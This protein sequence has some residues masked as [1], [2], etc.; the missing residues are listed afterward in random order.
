MKTEYIQT[1]LIVYLVL[2]ATADIMRKKLSVVFLLI[3]VIPA[4]LTVIAAILGTEGE[5]KSGLLQC[6]GGAV[7]GALFIPISLAFRNKIGLADAII[8][9]IC[10]TV[11]GYAGIT[12]VILFSFL[13]GGLYAAAMLAIGRMTGKSTFA[14]VPFILLGSAMTMIL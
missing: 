12:S 3:G 8:F 13:L 4:A 14:F 9:T 1:I 7:I 10:G 2:A 6:A 5:V 11:F